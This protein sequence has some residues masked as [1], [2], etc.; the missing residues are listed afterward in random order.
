[1]GKSKPVSEAASL[2]DLNCP[3]SQTRLVGAASCGSCPSA[4]LAATATATV[5]LAVT[6][7]SLSTHSHANTRAS[8]T[9]SRALG[10]P[11]GALH[12]LLAVSSSVKQGGPAHPSGPIPGA[13]PRPLTPCLGHPS[14][15]SPGPPLIPAPHSR[16]T[17][18]HQPCSGTRGG[19]NSGT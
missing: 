14:P 12:Q 6:E 19:R 18:P 17:C 13:A 15:G 16:N 4:M 10:A 7:Y 11:W 1:M 9:E 3:A 2:W 5:H 8:L